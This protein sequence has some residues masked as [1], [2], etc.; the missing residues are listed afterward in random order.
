MEEDKTTLIDFR[1]IIIVIND[2]DKS[3]SFQSFL[4]KLNKKPRGL[5]HRGLI[6]WELS[7]EK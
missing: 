5:A 2:K 3:F 7:L 1:G 4:L 6:P